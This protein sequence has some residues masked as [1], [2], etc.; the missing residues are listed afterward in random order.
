MAKKS[1]LLVKFI[2]YKRGTDSLYHLCS[3]HAKFGKRESKT[4]KGLDR[5]RRNSNEKIRNN[6]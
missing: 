5:E 1:K 2:K 6:K 4:G 3:K